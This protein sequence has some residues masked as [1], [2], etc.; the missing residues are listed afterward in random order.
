MS[1][2]L[3]AQRVFDGGKGFADAVVVGDF[4][5]V[6]AEG[7]VEVDAHEDVLVLEIEIFD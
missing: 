7:H 2:R 4:S 3:V 6:V 1:L 5:A